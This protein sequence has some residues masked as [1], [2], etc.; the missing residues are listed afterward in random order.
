MQRRFIVSKE[1]NKRLILFFTGWSTDFR[2]LSEIEI[3]SGYDLLCCWDY[4]LLVWEPLTKDYDEIVI[5]AWSFGVS[6]ANEI[7]SRAL[8]SENITGLYAV[9]GSIFPMDSEKGI[10]PAIFESTRA[11]LNDKTLQK[12]RLRICGGK[13][14]FLNSSEKLNSES[15]ITD[16]KEELDRFEE[17]SS[18]EIH[19]QDWDYAFISENDKIFPIDN[20]RR[21]WKATPVMVLENNEHYPDFQAIFD[22]IIKDKENI[23]R[24]FEKSISSYKDNATTQLYLAHRLCELLP[25]RFPRKGRVLEIGSGAGCLT[26]LVDSKLHPEE[27]T[28]IDLTSE[29]PLPDAKFIPGDVEIEIKKLSSDYYDIVVSGST[30]QWLHSPYRTFREI[31]RILKPGGEFIFSTFVKGNMKEISDL[32]G[33]TL[34]YHD[35]SQWKRIVEKAGMDVKLCET[36]SREIFF[37]KVSDVFNHIKN[38][39]V[40]SLNGKNKSVREIKELIQRYPKDSEK[41]KLTYNTLVINAVKPI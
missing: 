38:T 36:E 19:T 34:L 27:F 9:N 8:L 23:G 40:N 1:G 14:R 2:V 21:A 4:R 10:P 13:E 29:S 41:Y 11:N 18:S 15:S 20:L 25:S 17:I 3:P 6:A 12:F 39:G 26:Q 31:F 22:L 5:I 33:K 24:K 32:T 7:L 37:D 16:L 35:S 28:I 30:V